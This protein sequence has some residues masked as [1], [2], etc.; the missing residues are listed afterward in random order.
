MLRLFG[1]SKFVTWQARTEGVGTAIGKQIFP[2]F[3]FVDGVYKDIVTAGDD[4]GLKSLSSV[5]IVGKLMYWHMGR[6]SYNRQDLW[7]I[8][9][10][11]E[12]LRLNKVKDRYE[13]AKNKNEFRMN[14]RQDL[15][16]L[17]RVNKI[18]GTLNKYQRQINLL[19]ARENPPEAQIERLKQQRINMIKRYLK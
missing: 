5:P 3:K 14:N 1:I 19:N 2:P 6:G 17:R 12:K 18:Q 16:E 9:F 7:E 11:K 10:R 15:M 4:K 13:K 8:R